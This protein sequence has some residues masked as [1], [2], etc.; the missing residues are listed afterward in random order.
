MG[1]VMRLGYGFAL[2]LGLSFAVSGMALQEPASPGANSAEQNSAKQ[3][4]AEPNSAEP[5][6]ATPAASG[7][8]AAE[9]H[10]PAGTTAVQAKKPAANAPAKHR[11]HATPPPDAPDAP[12]APKK[13]VVRE[14]GASEPAAQIAPGM[15]ATEASHQR[16]NAQHWLQST[17]DE[18][19]QLAGRSLQAS[20]AETVG[21]IRNY[22]GEA[23]SA[24]KE[25]DP[26][27]ASILAEKAHLLAAD[28]V[29]H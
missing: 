17:D 12:G 19:K 22:V 7:D 24:L 14:G 10:A 5:A 28:L 6:A 3:N 1:M 2:A 26:R 15:A 21:Q 13:I 18:L 23:R 16:E 27:R 20:Q 9:P 11:K 4:S 29:G 8:A 25:N